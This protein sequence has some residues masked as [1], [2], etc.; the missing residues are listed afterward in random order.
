VIFCLLYKQTNDNVFDNFLKISD[1]FP[2]IF[3]NCFVGQTNTFKHFP[4]IS[5]HFAKITKDYQRLLKT[6]EED[7]KMFQSYINK[8]KCS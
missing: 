8:F 5:E 7:P 2:K 3:Q 1:H 6:T 4:N